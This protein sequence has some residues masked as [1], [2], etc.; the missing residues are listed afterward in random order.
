[1]TTRFPTTVSTVNRDCFDL[2]VI[3]ENMMDRC[4]LPLTLGL[5]TLIR[6]GL[7]SAL[8]ARILHVHQKLFL[9]ATPRR[10]QSQS[11]EK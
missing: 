2:I 6:L 5:T 8:E 1:M 11:S 4:H 7:A 9:A 10:E 3:T